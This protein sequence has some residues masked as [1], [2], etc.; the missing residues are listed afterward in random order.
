M[1][2]TFNMQDFVKDWCKNKY[3]IKEMK[4]ITAMQIV[5]DFS[6]YSSLPHQDLKINIVEIPRGTKVSKKRIS[7][8]GEL[9][10]SRKKRKGEK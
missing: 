10:M 6:E 8:A 1:K 2:D 3:T 5:G 7:S 4:A 9:F